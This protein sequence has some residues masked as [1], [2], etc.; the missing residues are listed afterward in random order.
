MN[1]SF[2]VK[3]LQ[4]K[5]VHIFRQLILLFKELF[6]TNENII[7]RDSYLLD[8]LNKPSF[9]AYVIL[10]EN[11]V[12]GGLT[13]YELVNYSFEGTEI[14]IYDIAV[15]PTFQQKGFGKQLIA[16]LKEYCQSNNIGTIFVE[17]HETDKHAIDFYHSTGGKPEKVV[18]FNYNLRED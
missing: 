13:A 8:L 14:F 5:D 3:R 2:Q 11:E 15:K 1:Q 9:H 10:I 6:E 4:K 16:S 7:P 17:A 18:H 12:I